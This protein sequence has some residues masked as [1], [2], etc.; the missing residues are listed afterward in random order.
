MPL[1]VD[2]ELVARVVR[3]FNLRGELA[4]FNLTENVVPTFD[5]GRLQ[6]QAVDPTVVT[7]LANSQ[8]VRVGTISAVTALPTMPVRYDDGDIVNSGPTVNPAAGQVIADTGQL[9]PGRHLVHWVLNTSVAADL[10]LEWRN[11]ADAATLATW[12]F[13]IDVGNASM[14]ESLALEFSLNERLRVITPVAVVGTVNATVA[15]APLTASSA[16]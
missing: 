10:H 6:G 7:T 9:G 4:P 2:P 8:G 15:A 11:A 1:I 5:I 3:Q 12:P 14:F 13:F 16:S